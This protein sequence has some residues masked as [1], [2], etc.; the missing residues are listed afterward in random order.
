MRYATVITPAL[1]LALAACSGGEQAEQPAA[2]ETSATPEPVATGTD[3]AMEPEGT[4][5][6][7]AEATPE[8]TPT[9]EASKEAA[10]EPK[11]E[12]KPAP[13]PEPVAVAA[14]QAP[15]TFAR[16]AVCHT[17]EK[18]GENKLGPNLWGTYGK[19]A[20]VHAGFNYSDALT[21]SGLTWNDETLDAWLENPR[22][23]VPGNRMSF[24]GLKDAAK[25]KEMIDY[26]K[27]LR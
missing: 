7:A 23:L 20:G 2:E 1:A 15:A 10:A 11:A 3:A 21:N 4:A 18:G 5:T 27:T 8:A 22:K 26:L 12:P 19:A 6:P 9:P 25:R 24:P 14:A 13:K 16:C 17:V